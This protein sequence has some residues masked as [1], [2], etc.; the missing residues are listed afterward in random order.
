MNRRLLGWAALTALLAVG[1]PAA[2]ASLRLS[3]T[4]HAQLDVARLAAPVVSLDTAASGVT[5]T[6]SAADTA[7]QD[8]PAPAPTSYIVAAVG[9]PAREVCT[10]PAAGRCLDPLGGA[11]LA[12]T[13]TAHLGRSWSRSTTAIA[14]PAADA[15][16]ATDLPPATEVPT[17]S[18]SPEATPS[19][20]R[21]PT[22]GP[23]TPQ[24]DPVAPVPPEEPSAGSTDDASP[25]PAKSSPSNQPAPGDPTAPSLFS[26]G[27]NAEP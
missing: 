17:A 6:V 26:P 10:L 27:S 21:S 18:E 19:E 14:P 5:I 25:N 4:A 16:T 13:V 8:A 7:P 15:P 11:G 24:P 23:T 12:Y 20:S 3:A 9:D 1:T 2:L 22:G